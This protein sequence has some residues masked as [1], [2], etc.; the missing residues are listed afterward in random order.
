MNENKYPNW[1]W[2]NE[3][4]ATSEDKLPPFFVLHPPAPAGFFGD[5]QFCD[6]SKTTGQSQS[7]WLIY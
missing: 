6:L 2:P 1:H 7:P 5:L 3:N 4:I